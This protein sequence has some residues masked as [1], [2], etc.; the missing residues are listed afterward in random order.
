[1]SGN[2]TE[3]RLVPNN[4][5][6]ALDRTELIERAELLARGYKARSEAYILLDAAIEHC[7]LSCISWQARQ[8]SHAIAMTGLG[9]WRAVGAAIIEAFGPEAGARAP[10]GEE[11]TIAMLRHMRAQLEGPVDQRFS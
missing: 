3:I 7:E 2:T 1:M 9:L 10:D 5:E 4:G 11:V 8:V 6:R